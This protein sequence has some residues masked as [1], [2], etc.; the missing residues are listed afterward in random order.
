MKVAYLAENVGAVPQ[1]WRINSDALMRQTGLNIGNLA[2]W[3]GAR[4]LFDAELHLV[5]WHTK[6]NQV[7]ADVS[8]LVI[9]AANFINESADLSQLA[10]LVRGLDRPVF[11]LGIGAQAESE[12]RPPQVKQGVIDFLKEVSART[13]TICV[14]GEF[15]ARVCEQLGIT[16][17][18]VLGCPSIL[19]NPRHDLGRELARRISALS[20]GPLAIHASC[21]KHS[22]QSVER[23]LVRLA[24]LNPGS[25]YVVQRPVEFIKAA[26]GE[27]LNDEENRYLAQCTKFMGFGADQE[28]FTNFLSTHL[29]APDSVDGWLQYLRRFSAS[30]NTRIHGTVMSVTA[31]L[32]GLCITHDTRTR[33]L[34]QQLRVPHLDVRKYI[35]SRYSLQELFAQSG[36]DGKAFDENRAQTAATYCGIIEALGLKPSGQLLALAAGPASIPQSAALAA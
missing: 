27:P 3:Y 13:P 21:V 18:T 20:A 19:I 23:E 34:A 25:S 9:P 15:T 28:A 14:R 30:V 2:F 17:T 11:L 24:R 29:Y 6:P 16:R 12:D 36:F 7:P 8:A 32:P 4:L 33:E 35:E 22:L 1:P 31:G 26:L 5:G 10:E